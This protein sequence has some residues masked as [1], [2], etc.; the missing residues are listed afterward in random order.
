M[1]GVNV[2]AMRLNAL[3]KDGRIGDCHP[4]RWADQA[5][6]AI[7]ILFDSVGDALLAKRLCL[8]DTAGLPCRSLVET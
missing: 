7:E 4:G 5:H 6:T 8:E 3:V 1:F 2:L